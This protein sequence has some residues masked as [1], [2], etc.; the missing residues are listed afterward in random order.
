RRLAAWALPRPSAPASPKLANSTVN[1]SQIATWPVNSSSLPRWKSPATD[2]IVVTT[3]PT[4][5]TNMTRLRACQHGSRFLM[6]SRLS[7]TMT[8]RPHMLEWRRRRYCSERTCCAMATSVGQ[9]AGGQLEML[10]KRTQR[11]RREE[12]QRADDQD[13]AHQKAG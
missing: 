8:S 7:A 6:L 3:E 5:T 10:E 1:H 9:L 2:A 12:G 13:H 4:S 11:Q